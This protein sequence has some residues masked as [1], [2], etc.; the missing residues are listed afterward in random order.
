MIAG[1]QVKLAGMTPDEKS[2]LEELLFQRLFRELGLPE[3]LKPNPL[4]E[5]K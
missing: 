5:T 4:V 2:G 1:G 3:D